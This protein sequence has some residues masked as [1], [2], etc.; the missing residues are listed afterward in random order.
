MIDQLEQAVED[1]ADFLLEGPLVLL[2]LASVLNLRQ[3]SDELD[4]LRPMQIRILVVCVLAL[5]HDSHFAHQECLDDAFL[6]HF[7]NEA[8]S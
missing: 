3:S 6:S 5:L 1:G 7:R 2:I 8:L 4:E